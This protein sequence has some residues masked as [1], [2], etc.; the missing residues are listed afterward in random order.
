MTLQ[1]SLVSQIGDDVDLLRASVTAK[2]C[3]LR[4][5]AIASLGVS[6]DIDATPADQTDSKRHQGN[7]P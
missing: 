6:V 2:G 1:Q 5:P 7:P 3:V 4:F